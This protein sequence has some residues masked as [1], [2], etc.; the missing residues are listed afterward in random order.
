MLG[1]VI[2]YNKK[3]SSNRN[4]IDHTPYVI[5][6]P[7]SIIINKTGIIDDSPI[8]VNDANG[9]I[10]EILSLTDEFPTYKIEFHLNFKKQFGCDYCCCGNCNKLRSCGAFNRYTEIYID[11]YNEKIRFSNTI[12][13][14][15]IR[16][17]YERKTMKNLPK[18][19]QSFS[20]AD[21]QFSNQDLNQ[22]SRF[23]E[24]NRLILAESEHP[25]LSCYNADFGDVVGDDCLLMYKAFITAC[26]EQKTI[27][28]I[29]RK[30]IPFIKM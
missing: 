27:A 3:K 10:D 6:E 11:I 5:D 8:I 18:E 29:V 13:R 25:T 26:S 12:L 23:L 2:F 1:L 9:V 28:D 24:E 7:P 15:C 30:L 21:K 19:F 14:E 4:V 16:R 17:R 22:V 20:F